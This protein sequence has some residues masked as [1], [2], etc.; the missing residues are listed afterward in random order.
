MFAGLGCG[1]NVYGFARITK[2][3]PDQIATLDTNFK[4]KF[5][6]VF[7]STIRISSDLKTEAILP[8]LKSS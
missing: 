4:G 5:D 3:Y 7:I 1:D 8:I 6:T 2:L